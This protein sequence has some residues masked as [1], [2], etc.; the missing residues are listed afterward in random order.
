[1]TPKLLDHLAAEIQRRAQQYEQ[2]SKDPQYRRDAR[3]NALAIATALEEV[4][5]ALG[6]IA[7]GEG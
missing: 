2:A 6:K 3:L 1:M 7:Q 5:A 4:S